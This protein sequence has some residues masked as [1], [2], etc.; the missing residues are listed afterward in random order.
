MITKGGGLK[1]FSK[2]FILGIFLGLLQFV[3]LPV[4][5]NFITVVD[6]GN[7]AKAFLY[8]G[9]ISPLLSLSGSVFAL[10]AF[11][12]NLVID[13]LFNHLKF[14]FKLF[15]P[16]TV[17]IL[18]VLWLLGFEAV[19]ITFILL[20]AFSDELLDI[21]INYVRAGDKFSTFSIVNL[22]RVLLKIAIIFI[23]QPA[24]FLSVTS[25]LLLYYFIIN[26]FLIFVGCIYLKKCDNTPYA[27]LQEDQFIKIS[28]IKRLKFGVYLLPSVYVGAWLVQF[29][30]LLVTKNFDIEVF[31]YYSLALAIGGGIKL[32][33]ASGSNALVPWIVSRG[34]KQT[35]SDIDKIAIVYFATIL[36]I[37]CAYVI[38]MFLVYPYLFNSDFQLD[39]TIIIIVSIGFSLNSLYTVYNSYMIYF[40]DEKLSTVVNFLT[41]IP[42]ILIGNFIIVV[43]NLNDVAWLVL[44]SFG[45][46]AVG[47]RLFLRFRKYA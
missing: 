42:I 3:H 22:C 13:N 15:L 32:I 26:T 5:T 6:Y 2:F 29:D 30:K 40:V 44:I 38:F 8:I 12:E 21:L 10:K 33:E 47:S 7:Y 27:S 34:N 1:Y 24:A 39:K 23:L 14:Q 31:A 17:T 35:I 18:P 19:E 37:S 25:Q 16:Q 11:S 4:L 28:L 45:A 9:L 46:R 41:V 20:I 36:L 43:D